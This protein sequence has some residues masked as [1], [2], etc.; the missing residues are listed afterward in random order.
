MGK[1]TEAHQTPLERTTLFA[2][3][4]QMDRLLSISETGV[5]AGGAKQTV[6]DYDND[7]DGTYNQNP[8]ANLRKIV[9]S[10]MTRDLN[11]DVVPGTAV[12]RYDYNSRG[13]II[14]MDGPRTD[15]DDTV[16]HVY[17]PDDASQ[18]K[19]RGML[20]RT[21]SPLN[22]VTTYSQYNNCG[23]PGKILSPNNLETLIEY[24]QR[25]RVASMTRQEAVT[26]YIYNPD[27]TLQRIQ[28]PEGET[29]HY[30]WDQAQRLVQIRD[31]DG[32][33]IEY[34]LNSQGGMENE[35]FVDRADSVK[36]NTGRTFDANNR[37]W[38]ITTIHG[39]RQIDYDD[40]G[41][42]AKIVDEN[43]NATL[44]DYDELNRL[45]LQ[46]HPAPCAGAEPPLTAVG[47]NRQN[48]QTSLT[49]AE[50]RSVTWTYDDF[51]NLLE[52]ISPDTGRHTFGYDEAHNLVSAVDA[53]GKRKTYTYDAEN[54]LS[55]IQ[56]SAGSWFVN[57]EYD[58]GDNGLDRLTGVTTPPCQST[59]TWYRD[60]M[61]ESATTHMDGLAHTVGYTYDLSNR[62]SSVTYPG[63]LTV[64]Y[65]RDH[66]GNVSRVAADYNARNFTLADNIHYMPFGPIAEY[67]LGNGIQVC[68]AYDTDYRP[69]SLKA[70]NILDLTFT[71]Y[72]DGNLQTL[73]DNL[74]P[75]SNQ[76][77][78]PTTTLAVS[79]KPQGFTAP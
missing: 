49:D 17:Y 33:R 46:T 41:N 77:F 28:G 19:N 31:N 63:G 61:L 45:E 5:L 57:L 7:G 34:T 64:S 48:K 62:I 29:V 68:L 42:I 18:G 1:I 2:W 51:G 39:T 52:I 32:N 54:R 35:A 4:P 12:S 6:F 27:G 15:V 79:C 66:T 73:T 70:G 56:S 43:N 53:A 40:N 8:C 24:D 71:S 21:I 23:R 9:I 3:H 22:K 30:G 25:G 65:T 11:G 69:T 47:Y 10:G 76:T 16:T 50:G 72:P 59:H 14:A 55:G 74:D 44:Y 75:A 78:A 58:Q 36:K 67:H 20:Y 37:V 38:Q 13:Q 26:Q 60:G